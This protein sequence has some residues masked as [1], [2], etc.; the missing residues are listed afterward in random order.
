MLST[1]PGKEAYIEPVIED[2]RYRFTIK[3]G[4]PKNAEA[5]RGGTKLA[6]ANFRC[7]ISGAPIS[8]NYVKSEAKAKRMGARLMAMVAEGDRERL[9]LAPTQDMENIAVR[10]RPDWKPDVEFFQQALGFRVGNYGMTK[11]SDLF[12]S[13]QLVALTT[14]TDLVREA[15]GRI[16]R[17]ALAAGVPDDNTPID[18]GG[19]GATAYAD[20]VTTYLA[21]SVSKASQRN[22]VGL[23]RYAVAIRPLQLGHPQIHLTLG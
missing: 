11:W 12:T 16:R 20:A 17:D 8:G 10:V 23:N 21:F 13:R 3:V 9:Y 19:T 18:D 5:A 1:K 22:N 2:G 14:F 15:H 6:Q 7:L 4:K